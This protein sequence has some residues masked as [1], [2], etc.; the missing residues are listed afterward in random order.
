MAKTKKL[1]TARDLRRK[2]AC[3]RHVEMFERMY[4]DGISRVTGPMVQRALREGL[5][6][7]LA[8]ILVKLVRRALQEK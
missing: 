1:L 6:V 3:K 2:G 4:P 5:D 8:P 7:S